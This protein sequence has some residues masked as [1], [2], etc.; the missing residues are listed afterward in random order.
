MDAR[1]LLDTP[2][3]AREEL[4]KTGWTGSF[5]NY[6]TWHIY[7]RSLNAICLCLHR[8]LRLP[9]TILCLYPQY[10]Y[11]SIT[12]ES[13]HMTVH[14]MTTPRAQQEWQYPLHVVVRADGK[15]PYQPK[16]VSGLYLHLFSHDRALAHELAC[17]RQ[18]CPLPE[19]KYEAQIG[20]REME[21]Q[22]ARTAPVEHILAK[23]SLETLASKAAAHIAHLR[24]PVAVMNCTL[25][26]TSIA[27]TALLDCVTSPNPAAPIRSPRPTLVPTPQA[28]GCLRGSPFGNTTEVGV[29]SPREYMRWNL[30][31]VSS[32][33]HQR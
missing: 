18:V 14:N 20:L 27:G 28:S 12:L 6:G 19:R 26:R 25:C 21:E 15:F 9:I 8:L 10:H 16:I 29:E 13:S 11:C 23:W 4:T 24:N 1:I 5:E 33:D 32:L 3:Q 30:R 2:K 22:A 7:Q 31:I 17:R